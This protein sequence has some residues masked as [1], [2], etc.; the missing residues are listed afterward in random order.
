MDLSEE[1]Y[2]CFI[3]DQY[4]SIRSRSCQSFT[5]KR[6]WG[7]DQN[8]ANR[9][10][11]ETGGQWMVVPGWN[12]PREESAGIPACAVC[13]S[14]YGA[15][16]RRRESNP[17]RRQSPADR[18]R[19]CGFA[20]GG[21]AR[22]GAAAPEAEDRSGGSPESL[23]GEASGPP[24]VPPPAGAPEEPLRDHEEPD[25]PEFPSRSSVGRNTTPDQAA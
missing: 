19:S 9:C 21:A 3:K 24:A 23:V 4:V 2:Y 25:A 8:Q 15:W 20:C 18:S 1:V 5:P 10:K 13:R 12:G 6:E 17:P 11:S 14:T 7:Q 16:L 22:D